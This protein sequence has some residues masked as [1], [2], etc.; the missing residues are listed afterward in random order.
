MASGIEVEGLDE[1]EKLLEDMV[2]DFSDK[3]KS[4]KAG[5]EVIAKGLEDDTPVGPTGELAEIKTTVR[6]KELA[7]EGIARSKAFYDIFQN[8]GTSEQKAHVGYF[9]RSVEKNST[10]AVAAVAEIIFEK[11]R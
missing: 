4:V 6:Q 2:L 8:F 10:K 3:R 9:D 1:Y 11:M 5:I 7:T